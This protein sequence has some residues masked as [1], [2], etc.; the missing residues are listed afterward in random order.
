MNENLRLRSLHVIGILMIT[1]LLRPTPINRV[2]L[3]SIMAAKTAALSGRPEAALVHLEKVLEYYPADVHFR[4][5]AAKIAFITGEYTLALQHLSSIEGDS[6][7]EMELLCIRAEALLGLRNQQKALEFWELADRQCP[8]F[9][10]DLLPL[11]DELIEAGDL[12]EAETLLR[13]LSEVQFQEADVHFLL[14][15]IVSTYAPEK[16]LVSLRSA[17]DLSQNENFFAQQLYRVIEDARAFDHPAFTLA[18]VGQTFASIGNW[19]FASRAF[20]N[21]VTIQPD[22]AEAYAYLGL[23]LDQLE[24]NG[25]IELLK[26]VELDPDSAIPHLFLGM[27]WLD[28]IKVDMALIEFERAASLD[29]KNP[30]ILVQIGAAYEA[31]G[32][33]QNAIRSYRTAA[34][35]DSQ[36]PQFWLLLSQKSLQ[37]EFEVSEI[38]LPAARNALALNSLH[39]PSLDALGYSYYLLGD[40]NFAEKFIQHAVELDPSLAVAQYHL[41]LLKFH[42]NET[43]AAIAALKRAQELDPDGGVGFLAQRSLD[44]LLP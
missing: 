37:Y 4:L 40:M 16:A 18:S 26:A 38:A 21:A 41:G 11:I 1:F 34:E 42:Q 25:I 19:K 2:A 36:D 6:Q 8:Y 23:S 27:H 24:E 33:I 17:D 30:A 14:G 5:S 44:T 10:Q 31:K 22:Y 13:L 39:P 32:E 29:P 15:M 20:R 35:I 7:V 28:Q 9:T 3:N 12:E 43:E